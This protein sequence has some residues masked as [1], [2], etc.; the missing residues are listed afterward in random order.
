[1][2]LSFFEDFAG[3]F[4]FDAI[5]VV[6]MPA[7]DIPDFDFS[8]PEFDMPEINMPDFEFPDVGGDG[9]VFDELGDLFTFDN[10]NKVISVGS[11][12][13]DLKSKRERAKSINNTR[14]RTVVPGVRP[15]Q[16]PPGV[17][18]SP[19]RQPGLPSLIPA[20]SAPILMAGAVGVAA[21]FLLS[22]SR[23]GK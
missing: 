16:V 5:D 13:V 12:V 15:S 18:V 11:K 3:D 14:K 9:G 21:L 1:M 20:G 2:Q 22:P 10:L 17:P 7:F 4:A 19:Y 8:L 6:D 23:K